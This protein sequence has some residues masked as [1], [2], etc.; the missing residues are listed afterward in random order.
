MQILKNN[1][2]K[3]VYIELQKNVNFVKASPK[4]QILSNGHGK[5][6]FRE[7]ATNKKGISTRNSKKDVF[8]PESGNKRKF[9]QMIEEE[10]RISSNAC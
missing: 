8:L 5:R 6:K 4:P 10:T 1:R 7:K 9:H 2:E 3:N